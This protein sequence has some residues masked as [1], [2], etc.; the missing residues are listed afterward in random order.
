M[1]C[2]AG[3]LSTYS[4]F[5][6]MTA[7]SDR[8]H[9]L[10]DEETREVQQIL[11]VMMDD[12]HAVCRVNGFHYVLTGGGALG[13]V[14]HKG[15]IPW[16]DDLDVCLPRRDYDRF[17]QCMMEAYPEKY[18]IQEIHA[19]PDYDLNFMKVRLVGTT[20]C[21]ILDPEPEKAGVFID[22]FS[23]ENVR[24]GKLARKFQRLFSD[25]LQFICSCIRIRKKREK[26]YELAGNSGEA[27]SAIRRKS[28]IA[29]PFSIIPFRRWLIMTDR[30]IS[31]CKNESSRDLAIPAGVRHF[32]G[33]L[34]PRDWFFPEREADFAGRKYCIMAQA[35]KYLF[36]MYGDYMEI[37]PVEKRERHG[38]LEFSLT[39]EKTAVK[40][41]TSIT[42]S[43]ADRK[44][45]GM[46]S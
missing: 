36:Q 37:P 35:E 4:L 24:D 38:L 23:I 7:G 6:N 16:D 39:K 44:G 27:K 34:C 46:E 18:Y 10:T 33:E 28:A 17:R 45:G 3:S 20:F 14:R 15:F 1:K 42:I 26:L 43:A 8:V 25:G 40:E 5:K 29:V 22:V 41:Q 12:I 21:E 11:L 13:A 19:C 31:R 30:V 9:T 32:Y 2:M